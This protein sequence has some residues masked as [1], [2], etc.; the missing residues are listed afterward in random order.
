LKIERN[1]RNIQ[2][3]VIPDSRGDLTFIE[4]GVHIPFEIKRVFYLYNIPDGESR[5]GHAL[6]D[7]HQILVAVAGSFDVIL[8]DG[9]EKTECRLSN[10]GRALHIQPRVW[11]ELRNF[12][13]GAVCL[14]MASEKY[15]ESAYF[16]SYQTFIDSYEIE[17]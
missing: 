13:A 5:A 8:D 7:C 15:S 4:G 11:R 10:P 6:R 1:Y 9:S 3:P 12:S 14:V 2:L 17:Q 16:R